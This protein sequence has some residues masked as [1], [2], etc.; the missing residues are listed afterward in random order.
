MSPEPPVTLSTNPT[1]APDPGAS[2]QTESRGEPKGVG[3]ILR[4]IFGVL[5]VLL[6]LNSPYLIA[7]L[8]MLAMGLALLPPSAG[9]FERRTGIEL[10][11]ARRTMIIVGGFLLIIIAGLFVPDEPESARD[12]AG[13]W[14]RFYADYSSN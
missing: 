12:R 14:G 5:F 4:W 2:E 13:F 3:H 9:W 10:G 6:G 1:P 11:R 8:I 7:Q